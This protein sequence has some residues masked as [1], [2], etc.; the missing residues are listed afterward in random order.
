MFVGALVASGRILRERHQA[1]VPTTH[2]PPFPLSTH[3]HSGPRAGIQ[4]RGQVPTPPGKLGPERAAGHR[5]EEQ[6]P[7]AVA[8]KRGLE[9][10]V[11]QLAPANHYL[12]PQPLVRRRRLQR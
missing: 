3:R 2:L 4:G 12:R 11:P 7:F 9:H 10:P 6:P 8:V 1:V 5:P